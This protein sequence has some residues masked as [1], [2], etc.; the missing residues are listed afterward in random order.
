MIYKKLLMV[1]SN[2]FKRGERVKE[3][4]LCPYNYNQFLN[5]SITYRKVEIPFVCEGWIK[6]DN[7]YYLELNTTFGTVYITDYYYTL[8]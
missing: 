1:C 7:A 6:I 3:F 8:C 4:N 5:K 2:H